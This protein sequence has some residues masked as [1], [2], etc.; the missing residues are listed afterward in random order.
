MEE[1]STRIKEFEKDLRDQLLN[2][3]IQAQGLIN[4][5]MKVLARLEKHVNEEV[6]MKRLEHVFGETPRNGRIWPDYVILHH[7]TTRDGATVSWGAIRNYHVRHLGWQDIGYHAGI[8]EI[9]GHVEILIGRIPGEIGAHCL[10]QAMNR[11]SVG[12]CVVGNFDVNPVPEPKWQAALELTAWLCRVYRIDPEN[13][14]G[15]REV[16]RDGRTCPG[17]QFDMPRFRQELSACGV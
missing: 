11:R 9:G 12:V 13:V 5:G 4:G 14:L 10:S 17:D 2:S 16:A 1:R 6:T 8:E 15:H 7:S 3:L